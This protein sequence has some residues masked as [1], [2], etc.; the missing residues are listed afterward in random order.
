[1]LEMR[2]QSKSK[3]NMNHA[4]LLQNEQRKLHAH[5][6]KKRTTRTVNASMVTIDD[7]DNSE[8]RE[9]KYSE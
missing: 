3:N 2:T 1:M 6:K 4:H 9:K 7:I 8:W 5:E